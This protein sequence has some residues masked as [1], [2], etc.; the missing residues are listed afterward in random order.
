M[1]CFIWIDPSD[2][3][4]PYSNEAGW[5]VASTTL[6]ILALPLLNETSPRHPIRASGSSLIGLGESARS[7]FTAIEVYTTHLAFTVGHH[8][9]PAFATVVLGPLRLD[10]SGP[11]A[12]GS[13]LLPGGCEQGPGGS[14]RVVVR[15]TNLPAAIEALR[16]AGHGFG[17]PW[18]R[19]RA[20]GRSKSRIRTETVSSFLNRP[21]RNRSTYS[22]PGSSSR[23]LSI[24]SLGRRELWVRFGVRV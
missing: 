6:G 9:P 14:N 17:I 7:L 1:G 13:R 21:P 3:T 10:L 18:R 15:V 12:S 19:D 5:D 16:N 2:L 24:T 22:A 23:A 8:E 11:G 20:A 4:S